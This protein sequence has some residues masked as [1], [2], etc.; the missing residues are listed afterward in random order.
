MGQARPQLD[1]S[2][3]HHA[4]A[5]LTA[6]IGVTMSAD[7]AAQITL[8]FTVSTATFGVVAHLAAWVIIGAGL[9]ICAVYLRWTIR[10]QPERTRTPHA[11]STPGSESPPPPTEPRRDAD[12]NS[13]AGKLAV[14]TGGGSGI[15]RELVRQLATQGCSVASCDWRRRRDRGYR[16]D[17]AVRRRGR[18]SRQRPRVRR[19]RRGTGEPVPRRAAAAPRGRARRPGVQQRRHRRRQQL[20]HRQAGRSG[21]ARSRSTGGVCTTAHARSCR[22]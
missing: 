12:M 11:E 19:L 17:R 20:R 15:G 7:A 6:I 9:A 8:A 22:C 13:F 21:S 3:A 14:V 1:A 2:D 4:L 5:V 18:R 16:R 10:R